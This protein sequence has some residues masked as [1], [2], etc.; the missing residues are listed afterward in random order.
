MALRKV[1]GTLIGLPVSLG[2]YEFLHSSISPSPPLPLSYSP[3]MLSTHY[4]HKPFTVI[5]RI[6][7]VA[8]SI[9]PL[10]LFNTPTKLTSTLISLGPAWIKFGQQ[11]SI[12]PDIIPPNY[13]QGLSSLHDNCPS[14]PDSEALSIIEE[15]LSSTIEET[16]HPNSL[17]RVA[18][19]SLGQ[20]YKGRLLSTNESV[21][22]KVQR[23]GISR[24]V[25]LD[26]YIAR[27]LCLL[28]DKVVPMV[29]SQKTMYVE[30]CDCFAGGSWGE[31]DYMREGRNQELF[32][33]ELGKRGVKVKIPRV[34]SE[35]HSGSSKILITSWVDGVKLSSCPPSVINRLI[36]VGVE[37]FLTQL[38]DIGK[39]HSDP[40]P[41]NLLVITGEDGEPTLS[42]ID[43][44]LTA[45]V[46]DRERRAMT[47]AIVNLL[48]GDYK[49]LIRRDAKELGFLDMEYDTREIEPLLTKVLRDGLLEGGS[50]LR[51]RKDKL[52][53]ISGELNEIFFKYEFSV[54]PFFALVTRGLGLLEGIALKGDEEFDIFKAAMPYAKRRAKIIFGYV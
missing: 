4:T 7:T 19:A 5:S 33:E 35:L 36:P 32:R 18:A 51:K 31:L 27:L 46:D 43:F 47:G 38:L 8:S 50:N 13:L 22:V 24:S 39:F 12:R 34:H 45:D 1:A 9:P 21:A 30:L 28:A 49:L 3:T 48:K 52:S 6:I 42:L 17:H 10:L 23:P 26:L 16:F 40:H 54:P 53:A 41:G 44:G 20:V 25:S 29:S 14:F 15:E 11:L 2:A 37:L